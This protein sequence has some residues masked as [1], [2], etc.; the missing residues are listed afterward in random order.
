LEISIENRNQKMEISKRKKSI[1]S[2]QDLEVYQRF[3]NLMLIVLREVVPKLPAEERFDLKDQLRRCSK[4]GPALVAEGFAKR[5]QLRSWRKYLE[6]AT[7]EANEMIHHL[8]VCRDAYPDFIDKNL[9]NEL[10]DE[11]DIVNRQIFY[12][13]KSWKNFHEKY[14]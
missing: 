2:F 9:C 10:I 11:Y 6:D 5:Y 1:K 8:S 13:R 7:G 4:A 12:L 3:Y 14:N